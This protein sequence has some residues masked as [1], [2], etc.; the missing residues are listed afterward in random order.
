MGIHM[1][2]RIVVVGSIN[3]DLVAATPRIPIAG[4]TVAGLS[5]QT[6]PGGKG[7]N[8]AVAASRLGGSVSMLGKLGTDVFGT[9]LRESLEESKVDTDGI[10]VVPGPSG[11][12]VIATDEQGQNAITVVAGANGHLL[13]VDLEAHIGLIRGAG[14]LLTQLEI[15][16]E[17]VEYLACIANRE[18]VPLVLD[19]APARL[20]PTSLLKRVDW[21]TPNETEG[22]F[23][24][25]R[26]PG[27]LRKEV[28][29]DA[30]N[31][32]LA[33][34]S[35][36]VIFKLGERGCYVALSGGTRQLMPAYSVRAIDTT[37]AGDAFNGAFAVA[38]VKG[39]DPL[40]AAA[41]ALA[42]AAISVTRSGAQPSM[43]TLPE[44]DRF[45]EDTQALMSNR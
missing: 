34:G 17:T 37:A 30:A 6:F 15:P 5:F 12:A 19:P 4:E 18:R 28:L 13:P 42:A 44:V 29:E 43:P 16:L 26:A 9:Q 14:I 41:W 22:C 11:I 33:L 1:A 32:L 10:D 27:E 36:N 24:L 31:A 8:Q 21:L 45:L 3:L 25:G 7:A 20:L 39:R 2:K 23:L 35:R 38:L 40:S